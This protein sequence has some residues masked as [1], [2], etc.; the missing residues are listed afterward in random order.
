MTSKGYVPYRSQMC[1]VAG[2]DTGAPVPAGDYRIGRYCLAIQLAL[3]CSIPAPLLAPVY[4]IYARLVAFSCCLVL[5]GGRHV[6]GTR[7]G[8]ISGMVEAG[9]GDKGL[10]TGATC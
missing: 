8:D 9:L 10:I 2:T 5:V 6:A 7:L 1:M 3:D 4:I